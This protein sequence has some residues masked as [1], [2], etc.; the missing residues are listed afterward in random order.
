MSTLFPSSMSFTNNNSSLGASAMITVNDQDLPTILQCMKRR[1]CCSMED[2]DFDILE[3]TNAALQSGL[4]TSLLNQIND[5]FQQYKQPNFTVKEDFWTL[6]LLRAEI[7]FFSLLKTQVE[8]NEANL[9]LK[10]VKD[11]ANHV[12]DALISTNKGK[13]YFILRLIQNSRETICPF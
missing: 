7:L 10:I 4:I 6:Q 1:S 11:T 12:G 8:I 5:N 3:Q 9:L 2:I 13:T